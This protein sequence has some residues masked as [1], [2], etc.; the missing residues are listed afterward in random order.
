MKKTAMVVLLCCSLLIPAGSWAGPMEPNTDRP[1]SDYRDFDLSNSDPKACQDA[2]LTDPKC[3]AWT[4]VRPGITGAKAHCW[5]K[6]AIPMPVQNPDC[7]S[8]VKGVDTSYNIVPPKV[9]AWPATDVTHTTATLN[10]RINT[11]GQSVFKYYFTWGMSGIPS[12]VY[13]T[14]PKSLDRSYTPEAV[15]VNLTGLKPATQYWYQLWVSTTDGTKEWR[16]ETPQYIKT[17]APVTDDPSHGP[18]PAKKSDPYS[19]KK[20]AGSTGRPEDTKKIGE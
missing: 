19:G 8:G 7:V 11:L 1:G 20:P 4:Y 9:R 13:K 2:C 6:N 3:K 5:L 17:L 12:S 10:G 18:A 15:S 14:E 16:D